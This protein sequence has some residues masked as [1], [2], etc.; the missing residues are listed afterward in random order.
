VNLLLNQFFASFTEAGARALAAY[1]E[2]ATVND[3]TLLFKE[4]DPT[5][6]LYLVLEGRVE[7]TKR[8]ADGKEVLIETVEAG[9][10]FG[11]MG[12]L[13]GSPRSTRA[14][15]RGP[16]RMAKIPCVPFLRILQEEPARA[17]LAIFR[18]ILEHL[19]NSNARIV[20]ELGAK[21]PPSP[22]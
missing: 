3:R 20:R 2:E 17:S 12:I 18:K 16:V 21:P 6:C 11:E 9:D 4:E 7:L 19:R 1:V 22:K 8:T 14:V 15:T 5:D 10:Y 13:D